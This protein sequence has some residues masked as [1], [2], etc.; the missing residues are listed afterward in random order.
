MNPSKFI[1]SEIRTGFLLHSMT[2]EFSTLITKTFKQMKKILN[3]YSNPYISVS[4]GKDSMTMLDLITHI[5]PDIDIWHWYYG[6][7][8]LPQYIEEEIL[9]G[10]RKIA[11][12]GKLHYEEQLTADDEISRHI[13]FYKSGYFARLNQI[14]KQKGWDLCCLG[15]RKEESM[16]RRN[17]IEKIKDC[18]AKG[19]HDIFFPLADWRAID[20]W[21]YI[22]KYDIPIPSIYEKM[23]KIC[24]SWESA[25]FAAFFD[26]DAKHLGNIDCSNFYLWKH[27]MR[28]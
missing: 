15:I 7:W 24:G 19:N 11:P 10:I 1:P 27:K 26:D 21:G 3:R 9:E 12:N 6:P 8:L 20:I 22:V 23:A 2:D 25:R 16:D 4:G 5:N 17:R 28:E 13:P 14:I 18:E